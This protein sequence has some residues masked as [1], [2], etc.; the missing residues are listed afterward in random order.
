MVKKSGKS[1]AG[2]IPAAAPQGKKIVFGADPVI[3]ED[4]SDEDQQSSITDEDPEESAARAEGSGED[5]DSDNDDAPEAVGFAVDQ[6]KAQ[7]EADAEIA[8]RKAKIERQKQLQSQREAE[9]T[10]KA[11]KA[12]KSSA[13]K[14]AK[15]AKAK[16]A[17]QN[18]SDEEGSQQGSEL[19]SGDDEDAGF[20]TASEDDDLDLDADLDEGEKEVSEGSS[21][22]VE[23]EEMLEMASDP[24]MQ[25]LHARMQKAMEAAERKALADDTKPSTSKSTKES[26]PAEVVEAAD[27]PSEYDM[28]PL[29][30]PQSVLRVAAEV[31]LMRRKA[32]KRKA[33][34]VNTDKN[35]KRRRRLQREEE[36][37]STRTLNSRTAI[38]L[39]PG[40]DSTSG[41]PPLVAPRAH[42]AQ[43][44][45]ADG[46]RK[47]AMRRSGVALGTKANSR[48]PT[49]LALAQGTGAPA[50]RFDR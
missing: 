38:Q 13:R 30:L 37:I 45:N 23:D 28:G 3:G 42:V 2:A 33:E 40:T 10:A 39:L 21:E 25:R 9:K 41:L 26:K 19:S 44:T 16:Q 4:T 8:R 34:A 22:D 24:K 43:K 17:I 46:F 29:P 15:S 20:H 7:A 32:E 1:K 6:R 31:D 50:P 27:E 18:E 11:A 48:K 14:S 35:K 5:S 36:D 47:R 49:S 12:A